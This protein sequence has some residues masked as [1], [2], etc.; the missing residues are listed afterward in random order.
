MGSTCT[1]Q[2]IVSWGCYRDMIYS[3]I[4]CSKGLNYTSI[5]IAVNLDHEFLEKGPAYTGST[6]ACMNKHINR[7][8]PCWNFSHL[9][10][11]TSWESSVLVQ[12]SISTSNEIILITAD[13]LSIYT[14]VKDQ[15]THIETFPGHRISDW[16]VHVINNRVW[17][18]CMH[19]YGD[20]G[21]FFI[22][23]MYAVVLFNVHIDSYQCK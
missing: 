11:N 13:W 15:C 10:A 23:T 5:Q 1:T 6:N 8:H 7:Q 19:M 21:L 20:Y 14:S 12:P 2:Q 4:H 3:C 22:W 16:K 17:C 9:L 18:A